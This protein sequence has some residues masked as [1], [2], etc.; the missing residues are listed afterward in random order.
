MLYML[1]AEAA[2]NVEKIDSSAHLQIIGSIIM[3]VGLIFVLLIIFGAL[4]R[5]ATAAFASV[6]GEWLWESTDDKGRQKI[7][8]WLSNGDEILKYLKSMDQ[9]NREK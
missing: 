9:K 2:K 3:W 7:C 6:I 1:A 4:K 5:I 8:R